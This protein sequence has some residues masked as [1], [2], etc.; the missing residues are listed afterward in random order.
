MSVYIPIAFPTGR[1]PDAMIATGNVVCRHDMG[2]VVNLGQ[3]THINYA[4]GQVFEDKD[5]AARKLIETLERH[6]S[7]AIEAYDA[8]IEKIRRQHLH[9][10][11]SVG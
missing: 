3:S 6:K 4:E 5:A 1:P 10:T 11:Q 8:C 2:T 7:E 9:D